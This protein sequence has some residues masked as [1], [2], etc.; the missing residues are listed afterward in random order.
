[1]R[2][3][4]CPQGTIRY[5]PVVDMSNQNQDCAGSQDEN[6]DLTSK[7]RL[8]KAEEDMGCGNSQRTTQRIACVQ[9]LFI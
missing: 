7:R 6:I 5:T 1:M 4:G 9:G 2:I 3:G 8:L